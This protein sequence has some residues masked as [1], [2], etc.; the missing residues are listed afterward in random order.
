MSGGTY[1]CLAAL[2][3]SVKTQLNPLCL[4]G[5]K[6]VVQNPVFVEYKKFT[7]NKPLRIFLQFANFGKEKHRNSL[8][9]THD[10]NLMQRVRFRGFSLELVDVIVSCFRIS[11]RTRHNSNLFCV[12]FICLVGSTN[13][14][15][16]LFRMEREA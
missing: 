1:L 16:R 11:C 15:E 5:H 7:I 4:A 3:I 12:V 2:I 8:D 9:G 13:Q 14:K 10:C 6:H